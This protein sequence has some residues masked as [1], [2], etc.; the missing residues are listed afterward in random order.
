M[1]I[2]DLA[3]CLA[4]IPHLDFLLFDACFMASVEVAY[5]LRHYTDYIIASPTEIPGPGAP[6]DA[7]VPV[8]CSSASAHTIADAYYQ[9]Y[10]K[11]FDYGNGLTNENWTA[12]V[13]VAVIRT[14]ELEQLASTTARLLAYAT[15]PAATLRRSIFDYDKRA[16]NLER[17]VGYYDFA[18]LMRYLLPATHYASW[19]TTFIAA[20]PYW[21]T[22]V[23]GY[24]ERGGLFTMSGTTGL[25]CYIPSGQNSAADTAYRATDWYQ[26]A[27]LSQLGW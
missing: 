6:Y 12:G 14:A 17:H 8:L 22:T 23:M 24:S 10:A 13:S 7:L 1:N 16:G 9:P 20:R 15:P 11:K 19:E 3:T 21:Q 26:A 4:D 5:A 2:A 25:S 18:N 27:G